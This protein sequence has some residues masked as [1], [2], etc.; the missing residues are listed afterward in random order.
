MA[1][2]G[3]H[4]KLQQTARGKIGS[5]HGSLWDLLQVNSLNIFEAVE[6]V[7]LYRNC[8]AGVAEVVVGLQRWKM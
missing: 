4:R 8:T 3:L 6:F 5:T 7:A 2:R 1:Q